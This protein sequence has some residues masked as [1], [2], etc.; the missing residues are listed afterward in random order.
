M[1]KK[2][3]PLN[4]DKHRHLCFDTK[5]NYSYAARETVLPI[6]ANEAMLVAREH[7]IIFPATADALPMAL[8]S[9]DKEANALVNVSG[10]WLARYLPAHLRRYPFML[11]DSGADETATGERAFTVMFD[12]ESSLLG[13]K[14]ARLF[15]E[16]GEASETL[17][18]IQNVLIHMQRSSIATRKLVTEIADAGLIV[19]RSLEVTPKEGKPFALTGMNVIDT[20]KLKALPAEA[21]VSLHQSGAMA[22]IH[23]HLVSMTNVQDG[24]LM[25]TLAKPAQTGTDMG[26]LSVDGTLKLSSF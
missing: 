21:V 20:D 16:S 22:L 25:R 11:A 7:P 12:E 9:V 24:M 17:Q 5:P 6:M 10:K 2:L 3:V 19:K 4:I 8:L 23:A 26:F 18:K 14:G 15:T 13:A 1:F